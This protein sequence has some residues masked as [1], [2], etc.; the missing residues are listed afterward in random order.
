MAVASTSSLDEFEKRLL[1]AALTALDDC[2]KR[3]GRAS[4]DL[5]DEFDKSTK[6]LATVEQTKQVRRCAP[7]SCVPPSEELTVLRTFRST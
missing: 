1:P 3:Y 4:A 5:R 2:G 7:L 6:P